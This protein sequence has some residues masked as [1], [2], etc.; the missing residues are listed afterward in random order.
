M[1]AGGARRPISPPADSPPVPQSKP[2]Q[3]G[4]PY[5]P[6]KRRKLKAGEQ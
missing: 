4:A 2:L 3:Q 1:L 5:Q 6:A